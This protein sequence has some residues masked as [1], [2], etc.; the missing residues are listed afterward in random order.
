[1][2]TALVT[3]LLRRFVEAGRSAK[4]GTTALSSH[5]GNDILASL[6]AKH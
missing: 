4:S 1:M 5:C 6:S 2:G 3:G